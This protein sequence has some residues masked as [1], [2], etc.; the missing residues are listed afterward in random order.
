[1][2]VDAMLDEPPITDEELEALALA[3]D[4]DAPLDADAVPFD[5]YGSAGELLPSWYMPMPRTSR[6]SRRRSA[7]VALVVLAILV[8]NAVGLC[9][10]YGHLEIPI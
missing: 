8:V 4:P 6:R 2:T 10:T 3:A 1:M 5:P 9:V 7:V